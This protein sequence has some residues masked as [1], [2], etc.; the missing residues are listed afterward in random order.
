MSG[1][2][3]WNT[4]AIPRLNIPSIMLTDGPHGL[5]KQGGKADHLGLNK[6]IP[7][8]CFP[9]AATLANSWDTELIK[10]VGEYIGNE[11]SNE[12]VNVLLGPGLNI[13]RNPLCG[14]N[15]EYFSEDPY[16]TG[17]LSAAMIQGI[18]KTG[19]SAC[20]KH[21]AVN[22]QETRRMI[23]D[24]IV[25]ERA[26][27]EL[28]LEG[29]RYAVEDGKPKTIMTSY[30][31]VNGVYANENTYLLKNVLKDQWGFDGLIVTDWGGN[32]NRV[33][34]LKAG[35]Q[36]EM[37]STNGMTDQEIV[38]AVKNNELE[39]AI[40]DERVESLLRIVFDT[41]KHTH[42]TKTIS[43]ETQ[44]KMAIEA[45]CKSLVLLK[46]E[47][48][49]PLKDRNQKIAIIGD[50]ADKPRYQG[51]GSSL[52]VPT[53]IDSLLNEIKKSSLNVIGYEKG[54]KRLGGHSK[55]LQNKA[56]YLAKQSDIVLL[57]LGLDE[58]SEAEGIDR[59]H[60]RLSD[61]QLL[62]LDK[63]HEVNGNIVLILAGGSPIEMPFIE[64]V[65]AVLHSYLPGQGGG[66]AIVKVLTG[67]I[68]PSGKLSESY[69]IS[70]SD[71]PSSK[72]YPGKYLT[73][74]H[75]ESIFIGYRYY[76]TAK[77][78]ILFPFGYGLSYTSYEYKNLIFNGKT[79]S[80]SIR[81]TGEYEGEE[82]V[83]LY[84]KPLDRK[85]F[86]AEKELKGFVKV[87]LKPNEEKQIIIPLD[88]HAFSYYHV[89]QKKWVEASGEYEILIGASS[90]D[91]RLSSKLTKTGDSTVP[92]ENI[93][94]LIYDSCDVH[95]IKTEDFEKLYGKK[96]PNSNWD[97]SKILDR[98]D[99]VEQSKYGGIFGKCLY[100]LIPFIK[101]LL[102]FMKKPITSNNVMF[103]LEMPFRSIARMSGGRMNME[104]LDGFI[105][106]VN[107]HFFKGLFKMIKYKWFIKRGRK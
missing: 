35:N 47:G 65:K 16:L 90:R 1:A 14:R 52:I 91:I 61:N 60:M 107:G 77:K 23:V 49:L 103:I 64:K 17:K 27:H 22:S 101:N 106:M 33:E 98:N 7:A 39:E 85:V 11:A 71:V 89:D 48:M 75:R 79:A 80:F 81:N 68:N 66:S 21:F 40:L 92:Y 41:H 72:I 32:N 25:D 44:H 6:S 70:Y 42:C 43:E 2:N 9:T 53:K 26:L 57:F 97:E 94:V 54:F 36:L 56:C 69:P 12:N 105:E 38:E 74:E 102:S 73:S 67:D 51:A 30:N 86:S 31:K 20:P 63:L 24:E 8:T 50:F 13:K 18:Q 3:F 29:F 37:P 82:I 5:R 95:N 4:K 19:V 93:D 58:G 88:K 55:T 96:M 28:Y 46:N 104:M 10:K 59:K 99:I 45:A 15:F 76:D 87:P 34:G 83:Q 78:E 62:L 84:V 100:A